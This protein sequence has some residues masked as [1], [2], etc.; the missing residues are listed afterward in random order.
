MVWLGF[1]F[2]SVSIRSATVFLYVSLSLEGSCVM[3]VS[4]SR[5]RVWIQF[6]FLAWMLYFRPLWSRFI[7][8]SEKGILVL[9]ITLG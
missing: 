4:A 9:F 8:L 6:F 1:C 7:S 3:A 2:C 5:A